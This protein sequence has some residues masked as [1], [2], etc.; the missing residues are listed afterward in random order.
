MALPVGRK[1]VPY[2]GQDNR[3]PPMRLPKR[4]RAYIMFRA[5]KDTAYIA[6]HFDVHESVAVR[7]ITIARAESAQ[8]PLFLQP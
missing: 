4:W 6:D 8:T 7:W 5:G 3:R 2:A 1:L